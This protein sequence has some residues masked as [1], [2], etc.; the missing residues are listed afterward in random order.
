MTR[1]KVQKPVFAFS[2]WS[3]QCTTRPTQ[4]FSLTESS[5][6]RYG[7]QGAGEKQGL[8]DVDAGSASLYEVWILYFLKRLVW[9][10][11]ELL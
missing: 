8:H 4:S 7:H 9:E 3:T 5:C 6:I 2:Y 1:S 10:N 11:S